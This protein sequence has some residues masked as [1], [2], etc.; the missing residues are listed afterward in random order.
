MTHRYKPTDIGK[1]RTGIATSPIDSKELLDGAVEA[2][3][4]PVLSPTM[5]RT[6]HEDLAGAAPPVGSMPPPASV[7]GAIKMA[8]KA[9]TGEH[10]AVFLD[11]LAERAAFERSGVR[12]YEMLMV[13]LACG[14]PEDPTLTMEALDEIC[15]DELRHFG[16]V[17]EAIV[18]LGGDP[19][20]MTPCA[21]VVAVA[22]MG[23]VQVLSDPRTTLTQCLDAIL[24]AE[25][26]DHEGWELLVQLAQGL[27]HDE[28]A[29][30]FRTA[31]AEESHHLA[32]VR[33]WLQ[34]AVVGQAGI[35]IADLQPPGIS[36][37]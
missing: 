4:H 10:V 7:K 3:P 37:P 35:D 33:G 19:T 17:K 36:P 29:D 16:I 15:E 24:I 26:T 1:N 28:L 32:R 20:V 23:L 8:A 30:R 21:D 11:K 9:L 31:L 6:L 18:E 14:D 12:L 22:S 5:F 13:K 25:L 27:D 2:V 34:R